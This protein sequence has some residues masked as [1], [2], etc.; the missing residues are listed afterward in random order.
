MILTCR[1]CGV[2]AVVPVNSGGPVL[3]PNWLRLFW[4]ICQEWDCYCPKCAPEFKAKH[5][6]RKDWA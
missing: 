3:P 4:T 2:Q 6:I 1:T 5:E